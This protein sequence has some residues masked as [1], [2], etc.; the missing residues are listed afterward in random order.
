MLNRVLWS[1]DISI[2]TEDG[3]T[4][5]FKRWT[6]FRTAIFPELYIVCGWSIQQLKEEVVTFQ[7]T[8][9]QLLLSAQPCTAASVESK[10]AT[11]HH[12]IFC[13]S[14]F[15]RSESATAV[16]RA[17]RLHFNNEP[18]TR[19]SICRWIRQF[20]QRFCLYKGKSSGRPRVSEENVR[21]IEER[22]VNITRNIY[23]L[24]FEYNQI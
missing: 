7:I 4:G 12:K 15:I 23:K 21:W 17:F 5:R 9:L 18:P 13:V 8:S 10:M 20:Q 6:Q 16:Q 2:V 14:E 11:M 19:K 22:S 3:S 24:H 1:R